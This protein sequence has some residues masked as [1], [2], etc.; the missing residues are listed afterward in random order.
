MA[1]NFEKLRKKSRGEFPSLC[2]HGGIYICDCVDNMHAL[3]SFFEDKEYSLL[4]L[5]EDGAT[6]A[7]LFGAKAKLFGANF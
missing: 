1:E 4:R 2:E 5:N 6:K 3:Y 7:K